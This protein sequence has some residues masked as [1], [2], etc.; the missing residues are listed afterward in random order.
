MPRLGSRVRIPSPAP[1]FSQKN[2]DSA[3]SFRDRLPRVQNRGSRGE[4]A[5][6]MSSRLGHFRQL[7]LDREFKTENPFIWK[8]RT[9]VAECGARSGHAGLIGRSVSYSRV[10]SMKHDRSHCGVCSQCAVPSAG[11][12]SDDPR[13]LPAVK[14][15][16]VFEVG[17]GRDGR[18]RPTRPDMI[19]ELP[20]EKIV[21]VT[22]SQPGKKLTSQ[23]AKTVARG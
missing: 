12:G 7:L 20:A 15:D 23:P 4:A 2:K 3:S 9:E 22:V 11:K 17:M 1:E 5:G 8:A 13:S 19:R 21:E 10:R 18:Q 14:V 16:C 6:S